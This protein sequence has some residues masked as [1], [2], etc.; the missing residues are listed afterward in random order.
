MFEYLKSIN[1]KE[2]RMLESIALKILVRAVIYLGHIFHR[3]HV[4]DVP[5][6]AAGAIASRTSVATADNIYPTNIS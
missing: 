2:F 5:G 4:V 1:S 6:A 3:L